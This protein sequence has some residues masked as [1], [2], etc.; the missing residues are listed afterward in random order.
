MAYESIPVTYIDLGP[1]DGVEIRAFLRSVRFIPGI[2]VKVHAVEAN[3]Y[4][5]EL[6]R[7]RFRGDRRV[8]IH[9]LA[10]GSGDGTTEFYLDPKGAGSSIYGDKGNVGE[11]IV[12]PQKRF[13][14]WLREESIVPESAPAVNIIKANIEGAEWDLIRDLDREDLFRKFDIL[15]GSGPRAGGWVGDMS[16]VPSIAGYRPVAEEI[17]R[18]RGIVV[19]EWHGACREMFDMRQA[20]LDALRRQ[21]RSVTC[22][23]LCLR[24]ARLAEY[25]ETRREILV[26]LMPRVMAR[27]VE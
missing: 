17:L 10:I 24:L 14:R 11:A 13:S 5:V 23:P 18:S 3:P 8:R 6:C 2:N 7:K 16:K 20:V 22:E 25:V 1:R 9:N 12:V 26:G 21:G 4:Y 15:C 27:R 19:E